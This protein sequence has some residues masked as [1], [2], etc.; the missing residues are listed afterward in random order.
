MRLD[1]LLSKELLFVCPQLW[2]I[3][4]V[5]ESP[6]V[7]LPRKYFAGWR[8]TFKVMVAPSGW[9]CGWPF[10]GCAHMVLVGGYAGLRDKRFDMRWC[11]V[12]C[13]GQHKVVPVGLS[14]R[15]ATLVV[16]GCVWGL[17]CVRTV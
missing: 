5:V 13:L 9:W 15:L 1:H 7:R 14:C 8:H 2:V 16:V 11:T 6:S 10:R 3:V 17:C 4:C 12:G